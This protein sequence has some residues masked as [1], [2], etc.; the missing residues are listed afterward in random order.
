MAMFIMATVCTTP[1]M[2]IQ[3]KSSCTPKEYSQIHNH[4]RTRLYRIAFNANFS[5]EKCGSHVDL[6]IHIPVCSVARSKLPGF[7]QILCKR[8]HSKITHKI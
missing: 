8:C 2:V 6:E 4:L 3:K 1:D 7:Y 5:C